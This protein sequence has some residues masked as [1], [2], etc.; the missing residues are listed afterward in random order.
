M[1][2]AND[3]EK[4]KELYKDAK[5]RKLEVG[6][7]WYVID[8]TW[9]QKWCNYIGVGTSLYDKNASVT[10]PGKINNKELLEDGMLK[11]DSM[12]DIDYVLVPQDLFELLKKEYGLNSEKVI[13]CLS[14][15]TIVFYSCFE[16][17]LKD[18]I[19]R[20]AVADGL[21]KTVKIDVKYFH[22]TVQCR[23]QNTDETK[24]IEFSRYSELS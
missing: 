14:F 5:E 3:F 20:Y 17:F 2:T 24:K 8:N 11:K 21:N 18:I 1:V 23:K 9:Y 19:K 16:I 12:E 7:V 22:V 13:D 4:E 6:Q 10:S 15:L